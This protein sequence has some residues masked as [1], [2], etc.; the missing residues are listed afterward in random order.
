[1]EGDLKDEYVKLCWL[2]LGQNIVT[3]ITTTATI[4]VLKRKY[5]KLLSVC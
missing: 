5:F 4:N 1:M 3:I 2:D